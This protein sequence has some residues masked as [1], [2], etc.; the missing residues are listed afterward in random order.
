MLERIK[1]SDLVHVTVTHYACNSE[2]LQREIFF[3]PKCKIT[4]DVIMDMRSLTKNL[5]NSTKSTAVKGGGLAGSL[6]FGVGCLLVT[7]F[8]SLYNGT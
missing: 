3:V 1:L 8:K 6:L 4:K 2:G 5:A 7:G